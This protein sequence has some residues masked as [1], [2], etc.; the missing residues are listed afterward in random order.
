MQ[1]LKSQAAGRGP[2][3]ESLAECRSSHFSVLCS[4]NKLKLELLR[5]LVSFVV[6]VVRSF[7]Y[8]FLFMF[9]NNFVVSFFRGLICVKSVLICGEEP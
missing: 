6:F 3:N 2:H 7:F 5:F 9:F 4:K 8:S 1:A